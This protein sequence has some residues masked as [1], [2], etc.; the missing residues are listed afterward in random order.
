MSNRQLSK[1]LFWHQHVEKTTSAYFED[2]HL[3]QLFLWLHQ[4]L[5]SS[6]FPCMQCREK[7]C[8]IVVYFSG[9]LLRP[10]LDD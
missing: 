4:P 10:G 7:L 5:L 2:F 9:L 1:L 8:E 3:S 6:Y